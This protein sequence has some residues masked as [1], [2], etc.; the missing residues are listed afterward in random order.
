MQMQPIFARDDQGDEATASGKLTAA[1]LGRGLTVAVLA[2]GVPDWLAALADDGAH[3]VS[4][5]CGATDLLPGLCPDILFI[6]TVCG[7]SDRRI[8]LLIVQL[9]WGRADLVV[10]LADGMIGEDRGFRHDLNFDPALGVGHARDALAVAVT[11]LARRRRLH[12]VTPQQKPALLRRTA[13]RRTR[14][15]S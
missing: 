4:A 9:R 2:T 11:L 8:E 14:L 12:S 13:P 5:G 1:P 15:F 10:V 7:L 3:L 6:D